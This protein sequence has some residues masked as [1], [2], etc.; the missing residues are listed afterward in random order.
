MISPVLLLMLSSCENHR[1]SYEDNIIAKYKNT[2]FPLPGLFEKVTF[3]TTNN[4]SAL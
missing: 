4:M 1:F 2:Q 3:L